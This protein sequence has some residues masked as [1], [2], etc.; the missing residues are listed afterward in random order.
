MA[1]INEQFSAV[2]L[3]N[4]FGTITGTVTAA[5]F[6][7]A[8][9][10]LLRL[11]AGPANSGVFLLGSSANPPWPM[12]AGDDTGWVAAEDMSTFWGGSASGSMD[13][14]YYWLQR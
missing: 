11:K 8:P 14:L 5:Q 12:S 7:E 1:S 10:K 3:G 4:V 9:C 6:P 2:P 13:Y